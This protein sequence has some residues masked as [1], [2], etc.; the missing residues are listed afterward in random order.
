M[1]RSVTLSLKPAAA[2]SC[3]PFLVQHANHL[4]LWQGKHQHHTLPGQANITTAVPPP[5]QY[6]SHNSSSQPLVEAAVDLLCMNAMHQTT[7]QHMLLRWQSSASK[8]H[9]QT[10]LMTT[11]W[12]SLQQGLHSIAM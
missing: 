9:R 3:T 2:A 8:Q 7:Q 12:T 10:M 6:T 5:L 1:R 11:L 4:A